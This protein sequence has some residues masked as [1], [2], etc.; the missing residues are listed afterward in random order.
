MAEGAEQQ[1]LLNLLAKN[2]AGLGLSPDKD[3][4]DGRTER[5]ER[6]T[7]RTND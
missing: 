4:I 1:P 7:E 5:N 6:R 3:Y 2:R